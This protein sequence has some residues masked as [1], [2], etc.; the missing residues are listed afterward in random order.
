MK[1]A[2]QYIKSQLSIRFEMKDLGISRV[3]LGIEIRRNRPNRKLFI[4]QSEYT[5]T[6]LERFGISCS[7]AVVTT[8]GKSYSELS[9]LPSKPVRNVPYRQVIGSPMSLMIG[10]RSD[11]AYAIRR[12]SQHS[13]SPTEYYVNGTKKFGILYDESLAIDLNGYSDSD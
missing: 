13:Q 6:I 8:M 4:N 7:K 3:M 11:S 9:E 10:T 12:L 5:N 1:S 2:V